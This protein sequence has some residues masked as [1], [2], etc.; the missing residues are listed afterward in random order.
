MKNKAVILI[1]TFIIF[2]SACSNTDV[3]YKRINLSPQ[4][5]GF[6]Q[7]IVTLR[8][9][10][11]NQASESYPATMPIYEITPYEVTEKELID[12]AALFGVHDAVQYDD[13]GM[14]IRIEEEGNS[15]NELVTLFRASD[16]EI[17]YYNRDF[18]DREMLQSDEELEEDAK[19]VFETFP[20]IKGEYEFIGQTS[21]QTLSDSEGKHTVGKSYSFQPVLNGVRVTGDNYCTLNFDANGLRGI[22]VRLYS[23]EQTGEMDMIPLD[24]AIKKI[25][26]PDAFRT[27][28]K[29]FKGTADSL[30]IERTKLLYVNQYTD[31]CEILQPVYNL[32]GTM[33]NK[34]GSSE[35]SAKIIAIPKKY[36][37]EESPQQE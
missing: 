33:T 3:K 12:F 27:Y 34:S 8:T 9:K 30:C 2:L 11:V 32:M 13:R 20:F 23:Y 14:Y 26:R 10:I 37:Y 22:A 36:T 24:T 19:R 6:P 28:N 21:T 17:E 16:N 35:F 7:V 5:M 15:V 4:E 1:I 18:S 29:D 25:R 31:G